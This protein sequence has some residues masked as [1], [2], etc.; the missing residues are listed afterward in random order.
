M[1][2]IKRICDCGQSNLAEVGQSFASGKLSWYI[3][4]RCD[5]C[6]KAQEIDGTS[7]I[8]DEIR[9]DILN[10]EGTWELKIEDKSKLSLV[11]SILR[12]EL[13]L[14]LHDIIKIKK[15]M[16][17]VVIT[18]TKV[19]MERLDHILILNKIDACVVKM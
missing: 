15:A 14:S 17:E 3:S 5:K 4:F 7:E 6:G 1:T 11:L 10:Q 2:K 19:E 12:R 13:N 18:G 8:P 9:N 16:A